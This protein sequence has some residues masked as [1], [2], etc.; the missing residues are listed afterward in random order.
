MPHLASI[1]RRD[2]I[3]KMARPRTRRGRRGIVAER[4][5]AARAARGLTQSEA[6]R[7]L[8]IPVPNLAKYETGSMRPSA[9]AALA[10]E[11]WCQAALGEPLAIPGLDDRRRS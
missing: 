11:W 2:R 4:L 5:R 8:G 9:L 3:T 7:E 1:E 10:L 6:A